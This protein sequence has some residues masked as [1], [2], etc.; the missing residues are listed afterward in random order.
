M[1]RSNPATTLR[2]IL[3]GSR[4]VPTP[5]QPSAP[6]MPMFADKLSDEEVASVAT[7]VRNSWGNVAPEVS[8]HSAAKMRHK[9][10]TRSNLPAAR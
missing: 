4:S 1:G 7:Y 10:T 5:A 3:E 9:V 6:A 2:I 8:A